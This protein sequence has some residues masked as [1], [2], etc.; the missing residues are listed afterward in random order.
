MGKMPE[1]FFLKNSPINGLYDL[2]NFEEV[3]IGIGE[4]ASN[5]LPPILGRS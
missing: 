4:K 5:F 2:A 3:S 1:Q